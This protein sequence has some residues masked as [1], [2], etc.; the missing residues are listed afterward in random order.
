MVSII[1]NDGKGYAMD[2]KQLQTF[3][4]VVEENGFTSA[5]KSLNYGQSTVTLHIKAIETHYGEPLFD[6]I[7]KRIYLTPL[8]NEVYKEALTVL[9]SFKR[10]EELSQQHG[11]H[12]VLRIGVYES[13]LHYRIQNLISSFKVNH[14]ETDLVIRHGTCNE[15]RELVRTG[16]LDLAFQIEP[17]KD[18]SDLVTTILVEESFS[19]IFP[20]GMNET[21]MG[22]RHYTVYLTEKECTY[23]RAFESYLDLRGILKHQT[24]ETGSVEVIKQYVSCGLGYSFVPSVT[25]RDPLNLEKLEIKPM[26]SEEKLYTQI[27][28][29]KDKVLTPSMLAFLKALELEAKAWC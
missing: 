6:R 29:H 27:L 18:F 20:K 4:T 9:Q 10:L 15:L 2:L 23:R 7:G 14:P 17:R 19:L 11:N 21:M 12:S 25:V 3:V 8:G 13:L 26:T 28:Y 24:M 1:K 22:D 5:A 16:Q